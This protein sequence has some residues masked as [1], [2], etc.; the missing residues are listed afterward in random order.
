MPN[1]FLDKYSCNFSSQIDWKQILQFLQQKQK[2]KDLLLSTEK[3]E[4]LKPT[5]KWRQ[6]MQ[7]SKKYFFSDFFLCILCFYT[8]KECLT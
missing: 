5:R 8:S 6:L 2:S 4:Y 1:F 7:G 3:D